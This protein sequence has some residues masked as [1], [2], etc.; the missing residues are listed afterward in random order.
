MVTTVTSTLV[1]PGCWSQRRSPVFRLG[2][3]R[4]SWQQWWGTGQG[5]ETG[6]RQG[7]F[8]RTQHKCLSKMQKFQTPYPVVQ[9]FTTGTGGI[10]KTSAHAQ[11]I[12]VLGKNYWQ[13]QPA[14]AAFKLLS[15]REYS[16]VITNL[17]QHWLSSLLTL[18]SSSLF[19]SGAGIRHPV[20][21]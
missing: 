18:H 19:S 12:C 1:T 20:L 2:T 21:F 6:V 13:V 4:L 9:N 10:K 3:R 7:S 5:Q 16:L 15:P 8:S 17:T 14:S 11:T